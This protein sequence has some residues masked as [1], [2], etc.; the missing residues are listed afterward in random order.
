MTT[1]FEAGQTSQFSSTFIGMGRNRI[2]NGEMMID[3]IKSGGTT[4]VN[5]ATLGYA[6]D[7]FLLLANF[8]QAL[9]GVFSIQRQSATPPTGFLNYVRITVTT[10]D[11]SISATNAYEYLTSIEGNNV[12]DFLL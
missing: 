10:P 4:V 11:A 2:I 12:R 5:N 8:G 3:Q 1:K 6:P 7:M 9:E